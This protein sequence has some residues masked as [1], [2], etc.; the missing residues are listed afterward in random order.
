MVGIFLK[1]E[2]RLFNNYVYP[3][4]DTPV[5]SGQEIAQEQSTANKMANIMGA[6]GGAPAQ[7]AAPMV[8]L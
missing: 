3:F 6:F 4:L 1:L 7:P 8:S 5:Q 2:D